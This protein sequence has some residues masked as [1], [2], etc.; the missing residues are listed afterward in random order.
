MRESV[1]QGVGLKFHQ[2][3][4]GASLENK[5]EFL[6]FLCGKAPVVVVVLHRRFEFN[7]YIWLVACPTVN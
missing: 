4:N 7:D 3:T 2:W 1:Q 6:R 5:P